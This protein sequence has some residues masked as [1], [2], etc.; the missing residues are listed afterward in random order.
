MVDAPGYDEVN[1]GKE[2]TLTGWGRQWHDGPLA[3]QLEMV[4]LPLLDNT[5]DGYLIFI[6]SLTENST[7][8]VYEVV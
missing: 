3:E 8:G 2:A 7:L 1:V 4:T 6:K 5:V